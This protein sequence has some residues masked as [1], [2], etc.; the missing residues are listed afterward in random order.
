MS[1]ECTSCIACVDA[2]PVASTLEMK[3]SRRSRFAA[4]PSLLAVSIL[5]IFMAA[6]GGAM[7]AG[8]WHSSIPESEYS[9]RIN[10]I[11]NPVYQH[12]YGYA[13]KE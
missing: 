4:R 3:A 12:A 11:D 10:D 5:L 7:L 1:D 6:T 9:R 13:P 2:C 8:R